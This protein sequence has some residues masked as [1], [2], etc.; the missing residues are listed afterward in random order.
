MNETQRE[1]VRENA[2]YLRHVRPIDPEEIHEYVDGQPHPAA[3][4]QILREH[5]PVLGLVERDDGTFEPVAEESISTK[6][7]GVEKLS[8]E[9]VRDIEELLVDTFGPGWPDGESGDTLRTKIRDFKRRYLAGATVT[10]DEETALGYAIYHLPSY[11]AA[12]Q[13]LLGDLLA[14]GRLPSHLRVLDVGAG[15]GGPALGVDALTPTDTLVEYHAVEPSD[16]TTVLSE[17]LESTSRNFHST[18]HEEPIEAFDPSE[19]L[20]PLAGT[21]EEPEGF[22]LILL[23]NVLSELDDPQAVL[24]EALDWLAPAGTLLA[25]APADKNTA[26]ELRELERTAEREKGATI[27][28]PTVRLW[29]NETPESE[30]WSF[31]RHPD[32]E[33]PAFQEQLNE[34]E[35]TPEER[36]REAKRDPKPETANQPGKSETERGEFVNV[37]VQYAYSLLT[38]DGETAIEVNPDR[39]QVAK[40]KETERHVTER[41][42]VLALKLSHDLA[43]GDNPLYLVGDGSEKVDHFAVITSETTLNRDILTASYGEPLLFENVLVLWNDD[44]SA[45]N[46]VVDEDTIIERIPE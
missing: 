8:G 4:R 14:D 17:L 20:Q 18:I 9:H 31:R 36:E 25:L 3:V 2:I 29:P 35:R 26:T 15:V 30:S 7:H 6:F 45:Y 39:G 44:E 37:D 33:T 38:R 41:V 34:G 43:E 23:A 46:L 21:N 42:D 27:Y 12:T 16:A 1:Q 24:S 5:A 13:Y 22:D 11:F 19:V 40:L 10:Y 28:A 32:I